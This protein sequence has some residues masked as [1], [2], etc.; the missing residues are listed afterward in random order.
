MGMYLYPRR[1]LREEG[2]RSRV[3]RDMD[4]INDAD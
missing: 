2:L 4:V 1:G 3:T